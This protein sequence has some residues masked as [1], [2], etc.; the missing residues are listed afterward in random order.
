MRQSLAMKK[1]LRNWL[2]GLTIFLLCTT[3][4]SGLCVVPN[5]VV[6]DEVSALGR[7]EVNAKTYQALHQTISDKN[8]VWR[9]LLLEDV[10]S[11]KSGNGIVSKAADGTWTAVEHVA[12]KGPGVG[13]AKANSPWIS[14]SRD[15][16]VARSFDS[17]QGLARIDLGR[18]DPQM[19]TEVWRYAPRVNGPSGLAFHRSIWSQEV[20][21]FH[22]IPPSAILDFEP[23]IP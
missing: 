15:K 10:A 5:S 22:K 20:T 7:I 11:I 13:G 16:N 18:V 21:I 17:G 19:Q 1:I 2:T 4:A 3:I 8:I 14:T 23:P 6:A 9:G 12:N